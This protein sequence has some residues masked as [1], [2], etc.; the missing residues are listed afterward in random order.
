MT[1][2]TRTVRRKT[3]ASRYSRGKMRNVIVI[4]EPPGD[5][6]GFRLAKERKTFYLPVGDL[7]CFAVRAFTQAER[8]RKKAERK[9][10]KR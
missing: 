9:A 10:M 4:I 3:S 1:E 6:I 8:D 2:V 5:R 7:Y